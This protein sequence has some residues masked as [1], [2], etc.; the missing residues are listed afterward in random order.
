M[1]EG[2]ASARMN[3]YEK[4][5][6]TPDVKTLKRLVDELTAELAINLSKLSYVDKR[7]IL[8]LTNGL[9]LT[10]KDRKGLE[11]N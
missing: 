5:K 9:L 10:S 7:K 2:T 1:D 6:H 3:Q 11:D 8:K 4:G